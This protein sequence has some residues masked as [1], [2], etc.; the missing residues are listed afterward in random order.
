LKIGFFSF[1]DSALNDKDEFI[2]FDSLKK[3]SK[4]LQEEISDEELKE[5][6][7]EANPELRP[8]YNE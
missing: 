5:M 7:I 8:L 4:E 2:T 3:V 1:T 6:I